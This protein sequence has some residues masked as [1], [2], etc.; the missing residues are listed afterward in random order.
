MN[1]TPVKPQPKPVTLDAKKTA[2]IVLD[3]NQQVEEPGSHGHTLIP[4]LTKLLAKA[5]KAGIYIMFTVPRILKGTP[6]EQV[7]SSY[8]RKSTEPVI[9]PDGYDKFVGG[10][11]EGLLK[12]KPTVDT[13]IFVGSR[14]NLSVLYTATRAARNFLYKVVIP[15]DG[16]AAESRYE[17][18]YTLHQFATFPGGVSERFTFTTIDGI[19]FR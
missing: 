3:Q 19:S 6:H 14:S 4:G 16:H 10:E 2:L 15:V 8:Q 9:Y 1:V 18:E 13:L 5:R 12:Q 17:E 7:Y 11:M